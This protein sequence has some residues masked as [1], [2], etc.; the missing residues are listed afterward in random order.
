[1][2]E[3]DDEMLLFA[4]PS[5]LQRDQGRSPLAKDY[6]RSLSVKHDFRVMSISDQV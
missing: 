4:E 5:W 1:M 2:A 6:D 3:V